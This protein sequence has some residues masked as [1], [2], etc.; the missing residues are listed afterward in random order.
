ML[1]SALRSALCHT[2]K[3]AKKQKQTPGSFK[4][5]TSVQHTHHQLTSSGGYVCGV[6]AVAQIVPGHKTRPVCECEE[7]ERMVASEE[8][9]PVMSSLCSFIS[10]PHPLFSPV[11]CLSCASSAPCCP[12]HHHPPF[13]LHPFSQINL[14]NGPSPYATEQNEAQLRCPNVHQQKNT[15][16]KYYN[17]FSFPGYQIQMLFQTSWHPLETHKAPFSF[18]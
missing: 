7:W 13:R 14:V 8:K 6:A 1:L 11:L 10:P 18:S 16:V 3:S 2:D 9:G 15:Q 4:R 17:Q 5:F 12:I